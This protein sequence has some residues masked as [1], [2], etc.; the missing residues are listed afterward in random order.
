MNTDQPGT[1][2]FEGRLL[3]ELRGM[4]AEQPA[5]DPERPPRARRARSRRRLVVAGSV[6]GVAAVAA[7]VGVPFLSRGTTPAYAVSANDDGTV[8]VEINSLS[9]AAGLQ[10][11]LRDAGVS[12]VVQYLPQG[13]ACK[14]P[15]PAVPPASDAAPGPGEG[16]VMRGGVEHLASGATRFTISRNLPADTTLVI[17]TQD[18]GGSRTRRPGRHDG[19]RRHDGARRHP[20]LHRRRRPARQPAVRTAARRRCHG[21]HPDRSRR[22]VRTPDLDAVG[23]AA[24]HRRPWWAGWR[25][26]QG[27]G[28]RESP[29]VELAPVGD[30]QRGDGAAMGNAC[31]PVGERAIPVV[32]RPPGERPTADG[33][34]TPRLP[35]PRP[36]TPSWAKPRLAGRS[37]RVGVRSGV[38]VIAR[39]DR[40]A[41][42]EESAACGRGQSQSGAGHSMRPA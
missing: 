22:S 27:R 42:C 34:L 40:L 15:W 21:G 6:A 41:A 29:A 1:D 26:L 30:L 24:A 18:G 25:S 2:N 17:T 3:G 19:H 8:T 23:G 32:A 14:Q 13:K 37:G 12:A 38:A 7:G 4:V 33:T 10:S 36:R 31:E 35:R 9:D 20:A 28:D 16:G 5:T 39:S 11:K